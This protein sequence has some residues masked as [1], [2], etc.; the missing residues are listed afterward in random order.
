MS[1][2]PASIPRDFQVKR[3]GLMTWVKLADLTPAKRKRVS[4]K[5][6]EQRRKAEA[7]PSAKPGS[8]ST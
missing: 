1:T 6:A 8:T 7:K 4:D 2:P 5:L 3:K